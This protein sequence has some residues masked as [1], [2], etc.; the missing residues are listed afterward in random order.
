M[1]FRIADTFTDSL[2][3]VTGE[4]RKAVKT[5]AFDLQLNPAHPS[6]QFHKLDKARDKRFWPIRVPNDPRVI[7]HRTGFAGGCT[8]RT[9][10]RRVSRTGRRF[11]RS[12]LSA[13]AA[14]EGHKFTPQFLV[15]EWEQVV[16]A[17]QLG[18]W[19][20]YR[21]VVRLGRKTRLKEGQRALRWGIFERVRG[22]LRAREWVTKA[23]MFR[24]AASRM[25]QGA[26]AVFE[27]AVVDEAQDVSVPQLRFLAVLGA[28]RANALFFAGD[29][30]QRIFQQPFSWKS[31]GVDVRGRSHTPRIN[32]RT[33]HQIRTK[34]DRLL[35][36]EV[37]DVDGN[38]DE[39]KG[40]VSTFNGPPPE[41]VVAKSREE[42]IQV[43]GRWLS[44]RSGEGIVPHEIGVFV[45]SAA[46]LERGEA[47]LQRANLPFKV[48]RQGVRQFDASGE[49][50]GVS[51]RGGDGQ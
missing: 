50:A 39:R 24:R 19:E 33:S 31:L 38:A 28:G 3:R 22:E 7:V 15:T 9:S 46:Q 30:G 16:D 29:A 49:R 11:S 48:K 45:R 34:A 10:G 41:I 26:H 35:G 21:D 18:T 42:E 20:E 25:A 36:A 37:P 14:A 43:V 40:T 4:E 44:A 5:T 47:A 17:W 23:E 32:Y 51:R 12:S 1:K 27:Y 6:L 13:S 2:A 8:R